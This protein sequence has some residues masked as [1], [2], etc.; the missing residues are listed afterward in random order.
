MS[1]CERKREKAPMRGHGYL[2]RA[3]VWGTVT[4][5]RRD[6]TDTAHHTFLSSL[7]SS[8]ISQGR[9]CARLGAGER[10][11]SDD[12]TPLPPK[13]TNHCYQIIA[14]PILQ[15]FTGP[16]RLVVGSSSDHACSG[17]LSSA[18]S[19][20]FCLGPREGLETAVDTADLLSSSSSLSDARRWGRWGGPRC[21]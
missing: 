15:L 5:A 13:A 1:K 9:R 4:E 2:G 20:P 11:C 21:G 6:V 12:P 8:S 18:P 17:R 10:N 7:L 3:L 16:W 19:Q 14:S